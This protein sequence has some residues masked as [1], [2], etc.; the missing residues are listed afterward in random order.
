M[1]FRSALT[2]NPGRLQQLQ[3]STTPQDLQNQ[4]ASVGLQVPDTEELLHFLH[5]EPNLDHILNRLL[6]YVPTTVN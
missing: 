1:L 5:A 4:L 3:A 6:R 2:V